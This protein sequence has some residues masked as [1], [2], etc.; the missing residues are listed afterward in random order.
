MLPVRGSIATSA[1]CSSG[2]LN[3]A[4]PAAHGLL[5]R[6]LQRRHERRADLPVGRMV[7]AEPLAEL[8]AQELL[9]VAAARIARAGIRPDADARPPRL[10]LL[11]LG[12]E[13]LLAHP[14]QHDVAA[15]ERAVEVRPRRQRRRRARQP[16]DERALREVQLLRRPAEQ[17]PR[18]RLDAVDAGAQIDAI[19]V[20]LEDLLL[21]QL[22]VDH[23][24][25]HRLA[26]LA[27]VGLL[28]REEE[29]P[30]QLLRQRAAA[31]DRARRAEVADDGAAERDGIDAGMRVEAVILDRDERVLQVL[32][33]LAERHVAAV[34]V[35]PEPAPAVGGEKPRVADAARQPVHGVALP[36]QPRHGERRDDDQH[37]RR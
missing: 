15:R 5:G 32:G 28:V 2:S 27:A 37:A 4:Q 7:A 11:R 17:M 26:N 20:E 36:Q 3:R 8:L 31:L 35:H 33:N 12:D 22:A 13:A 19:E 25:E 9:R 24:R 6:L 34:L 16:G 21:G 10:P 14:R 18:H 30:R 29:R 1:A 23:Q